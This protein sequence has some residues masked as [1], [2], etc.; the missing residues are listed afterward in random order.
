[1][2]KQTLKQL[3]LNN[4]EAIILIHTDW[5]GHCKELKPLIKKFANI[6]EISYIEIDSD[7]ETEIQ[8]YFN[9]M[10]IPTILH[11][12]NGG[13]SVLEGPQ[14]IKTFIKNYGK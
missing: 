10:Y 3:Q 6:N 5:C 8:E 2:D 7:S 11:I 13:V 4:D 12:N 14:K 1:M 9:I